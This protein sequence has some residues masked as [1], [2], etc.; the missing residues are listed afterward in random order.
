MRMVI[1][2]DQGMLRGALVQL[3]ELEEDIE[4]VGEAGDGRQALTLVEQFHPDLLI[5]D[6]E[7]PGVSGLEL[8]EILMNKKSSCKTVIVTTFARPGYLERAMKAGVCGYI[9]KD[10][11]IKELIDHLRQINLGKR[12]ISPELAQSFFF[13]ESNPLTE[14]EIDVLHCAAGGEDT[15]KIAEKLYLSHGTVRNYLSSAMQK[16][17]SHSRQEAVIKAKNKGWI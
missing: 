14:R 17:E 8:A 15:K 5:A 16:M 2:E 1:A 10:E 13:S 7:M 3:L 6:I 4:V 9:L 12:V 11:P